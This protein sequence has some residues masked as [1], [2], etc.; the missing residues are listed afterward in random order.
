MEVTIKY[1]TS[2]PLVI[3]C[4]SLDVARLVASRMGFDDVDVQPMEPG[5]ATVTATGKN[6]TVR[7]TG[8]DIYNACYKLIDALA[9]DVKEEKT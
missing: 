7:F 8:T 2:A 1:S 5:R 3:N 6:R 9:A 4:N